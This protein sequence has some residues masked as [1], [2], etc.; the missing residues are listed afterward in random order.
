MRRRL[1]LA[2]M[3]LGAGMLWAAGCGNKT[4]E[5]NSVS[6]TESTEMAVFDY[7][8][9]D[10][11]TL[12]EY[13]GL[14]VNYP[15]PAM[16]KDDL[17]MEIEYLLEENTKYNEVSDR[18]A[19]EG[20]FINIDY[21]GTIDGEEFE[22]GSDAGYEFELGEGEFPE[23]FEKNLIGKKKGE[24]CTFKMTFSDDYD[25][26]MAGK[27]AEFAVTV[28][29]VSEVVVPEYND[30]FVK[31]VTD[32]DTVKAY[33]EALEADLMT[34]SQEES[35]ELAGGDALQA[36]VANASIKGCP[37]ALYDACYNS[38]LKEYQEYADMLD[39]ELSDFIEDDES[40]DEEVL[41]FVNEIL[42]AQA[43]AKKEGFEITE[44]SYQEDGEK[45][46]AEYEYESLKEFEADYG[47]IYVRTNLMREKA[48]DFLYENAKLKE[49][50]Q[51][52]YYGGSESLEGS[53]EEA[54]D[55]E[56]EMGETEQA[57]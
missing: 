34:S 3:M 53:L 52:E 38:T 40:L 50:S 15:V 2:I 32:Y 16:S 24:N 49:M 17:E 10:Y 30:A 43:I 51:E 39:M 41:S 45:L 19:E 29:S 21:K 13:K 48:V 7:N 31:E 37:E 33:E 36:A 14:E 1:Y 20:D 6:G 47:K 23:D 12:G 27:E 25:E 8:V 18:G 11:V 35:V 28:N 26:G 57:E 55:L 44:K 54:E 42:V 56:M 5:G 9:D 22:G 4:D 46:A